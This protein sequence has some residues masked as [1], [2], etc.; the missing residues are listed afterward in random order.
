MEQIFLMNLY[1]T[2]TPPPRDDEAGA[3][4][5]RGVGGGFRDPGA[6][7]QGVQG[8][9]SRWMYE[10]IKGAGD[11]TVEK[12][13]SAAGKNYPFFLSSHYQDFSPIKYFWVQL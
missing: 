5:R 1:K 8:A 10:S 13:K 11:I 12:G 4:G 7:V 6:G 3:G 2:S 9:E